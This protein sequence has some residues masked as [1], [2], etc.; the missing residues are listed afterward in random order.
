M[1]TAKIK[2]N[3][4]KTLIGNKAVKHGVNLFVFALSFF[5]ENNWIIVH[6]TGNIIGEKEQIDKFVKDL[7]KESR[8]KEFE[9]NGNF[10]V[11]TIKEPIFAKYIYNKNIIQIAPALITDTGYEILNIGSFE[12][13]YL[14]KL[15]DLFERKFDGQLLS[16][17]NKKIKSIS[18]IKVAPELTE[19]QKQAIELAIK[20]GYYTSPRKISLQELAKISKLSF[21][22]FQVHLRKAEEKLIPFYFE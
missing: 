16:I 3:E 18:A 8:V 19:K 6:I 7:K 11:G 20:R 13:K 22:T 10:F 12:K 21:S 2:F 9:L 5:Y 15:I 14:E 17:Q 1:W 4:E